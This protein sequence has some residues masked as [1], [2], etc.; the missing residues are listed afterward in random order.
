MDRIWQWA[1]DRYGSR[2]SWAV[3]A[4]SCILSLPVYLLPS[5]LVLAFEGSVQYVEAAAVTVIADL[6]VG[7]MVILPGIGGL[8]L[9]E[10]WAAGEKIDR[11]SALDATYTYARGARVRAVAGN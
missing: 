8:R 2:Y 5:F 10:R 1:W 3:L 6:V 4:L 7:Y 9:V 11:A